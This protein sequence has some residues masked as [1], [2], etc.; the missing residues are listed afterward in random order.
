MAWSNRED[1]PESDDW[2]AGKFRA[3]ETDRLKNMTTFQDTERAFKYE[4][5]R[6]IRELRCSFETKCSALSKNVDL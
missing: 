5:N 3:V 6:K 4:I 2:R 1:L